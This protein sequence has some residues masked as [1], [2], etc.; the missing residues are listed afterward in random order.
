MPFF[1]LPK[2]KAIS[3]F[4]PKDE[5]TSNFV[6]IADN[7]SI[8]RQIFWNA[9]CQTGQKPPGSEVQRN[10]RFVRMGFLFGAGQ[11]L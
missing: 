2:S 5:S 6:H 10:C 7:F 9:D 8:C 4:I 3:P 1:K 11:R